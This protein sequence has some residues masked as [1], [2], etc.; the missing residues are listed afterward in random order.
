M[1]MPNATH[2]LAASSVMFLPVW[3]DKK[4]SGANSN[5]K[6]KENRLY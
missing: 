3:R 1:V 5:L 4:V 2:S 6:P